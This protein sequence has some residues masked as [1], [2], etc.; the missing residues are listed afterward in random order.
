MPDI[1]VYWEKEENRF[2]VLN[3][4]RCENF[5][6]SP[7][8]FLLAFL[9]FLRWPRI[10]TSSKSAASSTWST[11]YD[12]DQSN[13]TSWKYEQPAG[14]CWRGVPGEHG[15]HPGPAATRTTASAHGHAPA[16][17]VFSRTD[18]EH[19]GSG[20][21]EPSKPDDTFSNSAHATRPN[22][23]DATKP[24]SWPFSPK[25]DPTQ[26]DDSPAGTTDDVYTQ[27]DD[28]TSGPGLVTAKLDDGTDDDHSDARKQ[29]AF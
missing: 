12:A 6:T 17:C 18:G 28:G 13:G 10:W 4:K 19:S 14:W 27:S 21:T 24:K 3:I 11:Q 1:P 22:D 29:T 2:G 23:G 15:Q 8:S 7:I 20:I 5:Y 26:T 9:F 16:N 25:D